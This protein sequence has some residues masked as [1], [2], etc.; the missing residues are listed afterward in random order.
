MESF[1]QF[2]VVVVVVVVN[3]VVPARLYVDKNRVVA[4][5]VITRKQAL[6]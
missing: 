2:A 3:D 6:V 1:A 5:L 4:R